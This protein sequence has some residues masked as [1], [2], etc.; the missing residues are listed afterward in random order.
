MALSHV[1]AHCS[2]I[3]LPR[4][5]PRHVWAALP[6]P[7]PPPPPQHPLSVGLKSLAPGAHAT[8]CTIVRVHFILRSWCRA[9]GRQEQ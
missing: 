3:Q 1:Q 8:N 5:V 7:P 6:P 2:I 9:L 4:R